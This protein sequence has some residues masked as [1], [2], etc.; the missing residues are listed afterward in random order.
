[1]GEER[2]PARIA[3]KPTWLIGEVSRLSHQLLTDKLATA[4]GAAITPGCS[5]RSTSSAP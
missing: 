5:P 2:P 4:G 3:G 1:M